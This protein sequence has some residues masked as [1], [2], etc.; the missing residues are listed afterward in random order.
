MKINIVLISF[1]IISSNVMA[2]DTSIQQGKEAYLSYGCA[3]CHG[4]EG[5]GDG[6]N[7]KNYDPPPTN[8]YN[9]NSYKHG[10]Q[11]PDIIYSIRQGVRQQDNVMPPFLH[12][13]KD[14]LGWIAD[15]ILS[16]LKEGEK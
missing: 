2:Q 16:M 7:A 5:R 8:F 13:S 4:V 6:I 1:L 10:R 12:L 3:L 9:K 15:Y 14:E 11:K